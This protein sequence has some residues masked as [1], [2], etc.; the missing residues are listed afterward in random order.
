MNGTRGRDKVLRWLDEHPPN[1]VIYVVLGSEAPLTGQNLHELAH[2]LEL[3][4]VR[5]LWVLHKPARLFDSG[6]S[7]DKRGV[8]PDGFEER[9]R[10]RG[11]LC[12]GWV[13]QVAM[14]AHGATGAFLTQCGWGSTV[15]SFAFG[16][17][18]VM[19]LF[20]VD[21]PLIVRAMEEKGI[22]VEVARD[23]TDGSFDR[24]AVG[25]AVW[26]VMVD[27]EGKVLASNARKLQEVLVDQEA[28]ER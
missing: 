7:A 14:L 9:M 19:L 23:N 28:Q 6:A 21:Q 1:S 2:G 10:A 24:D 13:P 20:I 26:R 3:T 22:G 17:P 5:F 15:E 27:D 16:L 18:L 25:V 4:G 11:L 8:L 12:T